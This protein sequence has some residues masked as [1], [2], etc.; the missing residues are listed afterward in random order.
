MASGVGK[1]PASKAATTPLRTIEHQLQQAD[2]TEQARNDSRRRVAQSRLKTAEESLAKKGGSEQDVYDALDNLNSIP[3][4]RVR[5]LV[6]GDA[7][8]EALAIAM[9]ANDERIAIISPE[10]TVFDTASGIYTGGR[11]PNIDIYLNGWDGAPSDA[12][13]VTRDDISLT[14]PVL[15]IAVTVQPSALAAMR[16]NLQLAGRG[17]VNRFMYSVPI[18]VR[19]TRNRLELD[20]D[21]HLV[22][23]DTYHQGI[24]RLARLLL[25]ALPA[26]LA[27]TPEARS[28]FLAYDNT[29]EPRTA[30]DGDLRPISDWRSK[31]TASTARLAGILALA[32]NPGTTTVDGSHMA[33]ALIVADYWIAHALVVHDGDQLDPVWDD[34][35]AIITWARK[36]DEPTFTPGDVQRGKYSR[37]SRRADVEDCKPAEVAA[38]A[39][40]RLVETGWLRVIH[41]PQPGGGRPIV[42]YHL[43]PDVK[44][45]V[46][47]VASADDPIVGHAYSDPLQ[48]SRTSRLGNHQS[49]SSSSSSLQDPTPHTDRGV[50]D[51]RDVCS[52][53]DDPP[54]PPGS[55][56]FGDDP[57]PDEQG[58]P[59]R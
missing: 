42:V 22:H 55:L 23:A 57:D 48:T 1:S 20:S 5:R 15:T 36:R 16:A 31:L 52:P 27:L 25:D 9:A 2:L 13:R 10:G 49:S 33:R 12:L 34:A 46:A 7:T 37:W 32:D 54:K 43:H 51:V 58:D 35:H 4:S 38:A 3:P 8:P 40:D 59:N 29:L 19:G 11:T 14:R 24:E 6:V 21:P 45:N 41:N 53:H 50:R 17:F 56:L 30:E 47:N 28:L 44:A 26:E 18:D 39:L